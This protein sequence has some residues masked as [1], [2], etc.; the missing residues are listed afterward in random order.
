MKRNLL[1]GAIALL[2]T[3]FLLV[4]GFT[5][6]KP[7]TQAAPAQMDQ[8]KRGEYLV[9]L[10]V[11][12]D[13]HTPKTF[14]PTGPEPDMSRALSGHPADVKVPPIPEGVLGPGKWA[15]L[16]NEHFTAWAGPWGVS[17]AMNL[18]PDEETGIGTWNEAMFIKALRTGKH[19]GEGR[20]ILPP[21]P[22]PFI[23]KATDEDLKAIFAYLK[24][25]KPVKN[26][27]PD[28]I[29]PAGK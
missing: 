9:A 22:W 10:G 2:C 25:V 14:G 16:G 13:C 11:C 12:H 27:V 24:S 20:D 1:L 29:P 17:F 6:D 4:S 19:L 21:M 23:A 15:A 3:G 28:P 8:V 7:A 18:T 26:A 5:Q